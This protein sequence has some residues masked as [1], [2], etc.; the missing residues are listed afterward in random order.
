MFVDSHAHFDLCL[1]KKGCREE[2]LLNGLDVAGIAGAVQV[3][4]DVEGFEGSRDFARRHRDRGIRFTLGI[5][6]SSR[7]T[8]IELGK[9]DD[10]VE[11]VMKSPEADLLFGIGE[12]GLDYY[13]MHQPREMQRESFH[14]Q[15]ELAKR[16]DLPLIV[17]SRDA[18]EETLQILKEAGIRKGIMHCFSGDGAAAARVLDLGFYLS[19]A[20]NVTYKNAVELHD[21]A[22][23]TP[24]DRML[25]ETDAP[26]LTPVPLRG[27]P[28][29]PEYVTHTYQYIADLKKMTLDQL[30]D[31]VWRSY[32]TL[33][34]LNKR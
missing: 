14:F 27:K 18:L 12:C 11:E 9:M 24:A 19:F 31:T 20:G 16:W 13:R 3:S 22:A 25:I 30:R 8:A 5:H 10:Y 21:S 34:G 7:A 4:I 33:A 17:H 2:D 32:Q 26:F 15:I 28:N 6:P 29:R 1:E 23:Y